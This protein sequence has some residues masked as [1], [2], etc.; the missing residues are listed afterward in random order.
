[1]ELEGERIA[2][3]LASEATCAECECNVFIAK[4]KSTYK[5]RI[6][7]VLTCNVL[8]YKG[9]TK[10]EAEKGNAKTIFYSFFFFSFP[11]LTITLRTEWKYPYAGYT[12]L[13]STKTTL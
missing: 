3:T 10:K 6:P 1:M 2:R 9:R 12:E 4:R 11:S 13:H 7:Q 8:V 5:R